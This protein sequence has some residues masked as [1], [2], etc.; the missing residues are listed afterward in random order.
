MLATL[1]SILMIVSI[2]LGGTGITVYAAQDSLHPGNLPTTRWEPWGFV[3]DPHSL[4][5]PPGTPPGDY[6]LVTGLYNRI[7]IVADWL[8]STLFGRDTTF[9]KLN[10]LRTDD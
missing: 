6:L 1:T 3:S 7:R 10:V 5:V 9:I 8:L 2:L 4:P